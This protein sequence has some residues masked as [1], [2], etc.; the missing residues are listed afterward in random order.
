MTAKWSS[1]NPHT[2]TA[3]ALNFNERPFLTA[4][5]QPYLSLI[6]GPPAGSLVLAESAKTDT[7]KPSVQLQSWKASTPNSGD[8]TIAAAAWKNGQTC[9]TLFFAPTVWASQTIVKS[10]KKQC[11]QHSFPTTQVFCA[12]LDPPFW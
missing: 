6:R 1:K 7:E 5:G 3:R 11:G 8:E 2:F 4:V 10:V 12:V 9:L